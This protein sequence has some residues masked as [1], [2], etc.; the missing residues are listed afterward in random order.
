MIVVWCTV[1]D[2][3]RGS[4][5]CRC[6]QAPRLY[7]ARA[8]IDTATTVHPFNARITGRHD[9]I[10]LYR[11]HVF[12]GFPSRGRGVIISHSSMMMHCLDKK[13]N[14]LI[15]SSDNGT[16][17]HTRIRKPHCGLERS[18]D[19]APKSVSYVERKLDNGESR[20]T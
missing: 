17:K 16:V 4:C 6:P 9:C 13:R 1:R 11:S 2:A 14:T 18:L 8:S 7:A 3:L 12:Q 20:L 5:D 19:T 10:L 15:H